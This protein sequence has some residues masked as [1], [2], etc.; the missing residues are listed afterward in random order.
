MTLLSPK[1]CFS[2]VSHMTNKL[3]YRY[4][5]NKLTYIY[6]KQ[7]LRWQSKSIGVPLHFD[8]NYQ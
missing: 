3:T 1:V 7:E 8:Q 5:Y 2:S 4:I 6:N